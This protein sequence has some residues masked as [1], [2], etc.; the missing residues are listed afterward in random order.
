MSHLY[1]SLNPSSSSLAKSAYAI[2]G[3]EHIAIPGF[4]LGNV[5]DS[6]L[7]KVHVHDSVPRHVV[8]TCTFETKHEG[9]VGIFHKIPTFIACVRYIY[10]MTK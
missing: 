9:V 4:T 6:F 10:R 2:V 7:L 3:D 8:N 1:V 5:Y